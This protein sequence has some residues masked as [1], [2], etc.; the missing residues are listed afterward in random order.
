MREAEMKRLLADQGGTGIKDWITSTALIVTQ[1][2][3]TV[4]A[5]QDRERTVAKLAV[6]KA[7]ARGWRVTLGPLAFRDQ[8]VTPPL[9]SAPV[10]ARVLWGF[11]GTRF[12]AIVD[13]PSVGGHFDLWADTIEVT[14]L[15]PP[16]YQ[17]DP[18]A[19]ASL[20]TTS[21]QGSAIISP[22]ASAGGPRPTRTFYTG[23]LAP[24]AFSAP[25]PVPA[26]AAAFRWH[27]LINLSAANIPI[28]LFFAGTQDTA[29][30]Y[31]TFTTPS[32]VYTTSETTWPSDDGITLQ[33]S[34]RFLSVSNDG[35]VP[36]NDISLQIEFVLDL[37]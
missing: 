13:W 16:T 36:G 6:G 17:T 27:Q 35:V 20:P 15:V 19:P 5:G 12:D 21:V 31:A 22:A 11:D 14:L 7:S 33:P 32:G 23:T 26:M 30:L 28:P 37:E 8:A 10:L 25:I 29:L 4:L 18:V 2:P 3:A 9:G 24:G 34:T 1:V